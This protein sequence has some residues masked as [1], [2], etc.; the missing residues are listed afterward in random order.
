MAH[1]GSQDASKMA[2][3]ASKTA[4]ETFKTLP[5]GPQEAKIVEKPMVFL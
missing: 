5:E 4:Q 2:Q 1:Y 3:I